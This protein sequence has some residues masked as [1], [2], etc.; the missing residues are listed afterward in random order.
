MT[1]PDDPLTTSLAAL[2]SDAIHDRE[3]DTALLDA[4][5]PDDRFRDPT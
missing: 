1:D 3:L 4:E 2:G 5:L